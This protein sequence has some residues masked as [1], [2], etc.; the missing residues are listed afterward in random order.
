[1]KA[2]KSLPLPLQLPLE[3][4]CV[5]V[6]IA[7]YLL[8]HA[9]NRWLFEALEFVQGISWIYLPAGIRI[10]CTLLF[11][12]AGAVGL[13]AVSWGLGF[14][15]YFPDDPQ[16]AF[17][18]GLFAALA[19][20]L[21]YLG[22]RRLWGLQGSL[23]GLTPLRLLV[24]GVAYAAANAGLHHAWFA[25]RG[26]ADVLEGLGVMFIG[27]LGGTLLVLYAIKGLLALVPRRG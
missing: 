4:A 25:L 8:A 21:A 24:L 20:W 12:G 27:D 22:A 10:L 9:I 6:T 17:F 3:F 2:T 11:G 26:Q 13:L 19:P 18:G 5:L 1:M 16:K 14:L 7:L 15:Y 23:A